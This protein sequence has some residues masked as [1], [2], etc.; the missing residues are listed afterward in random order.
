MNG[1]FCVDFLSLGIFF[2]WI[3]FIFPGAH[4]KPSDV[5][6][7][8]YNQIYHVLFCIVRIFN[9]FWKN[10][11]EKKFVL[12]CKHCLDMIFLYDHRFML[13]VMIICL[14]RQRARV[15]WSE[16]AEIPSKRDSNTFSRQKVFKIRKR[17]EKFFF[18][19]G[20]GQ[21]IQKRMEHLGGKNTTDLVS[22]FLPKWL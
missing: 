13:V 20:S 3:S 18:S 12:F 8:Y 7:F 5:S 15:F 21:K 4:T 2:L 9:F 11:S 16:L 14:R 1:D 17:K 6:S 19:V 22:F 10:L